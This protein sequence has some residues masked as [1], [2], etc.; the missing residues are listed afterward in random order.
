M[1]LRSIAV[2]FCIFWLAHLHVSSGSEMYIHI[3][4]SKT[5][6]S[7]IQDVL[8]SLK[9]QL[10]SQGFCWPA[11]GQGK[12]F[13]KYV[14][15]FDMQQYDLQDHLRRNIEACRQKK[16]NV[17]ISSEFFHWASNLT[18]IGAFFK[19]YQPTIIAYRREF[20]THDYSE[21]TQH[22]KGNLL[23]HSYVDHIMYRNGEKWWL[24]GNYV[25][26]IDAFKDMF[27]KMVFVDYDG[28][29]AADKDIAQVLLCEILHIF[30]GRPVEKMRTETNTRPEMLMYNVLNMLQQFLAMLGCTVCTQEPSHEYIKGFVT[31]YRNLSVPLPVMDYNMN[32][33][34]PFS[35]EE[36]IYYR[37]I[38]APIL[39]SNHTAAMMIR[40]T[41]H[42][43]ELDETAVYNESLTMDW[44]RKEVVEL[45]GTGKLCGCPKNFKE[46]VE[47]FSNGAEPHNASKLS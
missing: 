12:V 1:I 40:D 3:G 39:Y 18:A 19:P 7:Y 21:Y 9:S 17:L 43:I 37:S 5:G 29:I 16:L 24:Y 33:M 31:R 4:P 35:E 10:P 2:L 30:C 6:S 34:R 36:S 42:F 20:W 47:V 28:V 11:E 38:Y 13:S 8:A 26:D 22:M 45:Y 46:I 44:V 15:A 14:K 32:S 41:F 25:K 27:Q 23:T